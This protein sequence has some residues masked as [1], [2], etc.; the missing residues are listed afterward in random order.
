M[1]GDVHFCC[2]GAEVH[3]LQEIM[4]SRPSLSEED[5]F[6]PVCCDVFNDPVLLACSHSLCRSCLRT[7]WDQR[8]ATECPVCRSLSMNTTPPCNIVLK[9]MCEAILQD[10]RQRAASLSEE[11]G[12]CSAHCQTLTH[13]CERSKKPVCAA[14]RDPTKHSDLSFRTLE[15]AAPD[16]KEELIFKLKPLQ[17]KVKALEGFKRTFCRTTEFIKGQAHQTERLIKEKFEELHQFLREEEGMRLAALK[18]EEEQSCQLMKKKTDDL[19]SEIAFLKDTIRAI[20][21]EIGAESLPFLMNYKSLSERAQ[22]LPHDP[23]RVSGEALIQVAKHLGNLV[24][25]VS[26]RLQSMVQYTPVVLDPN[27][28]NA[29]L[30]LSEDLVSLVS[31]EKQKLLPNNPE[32]FEGFAS[33]L[34]SEGFSSGVHCWDVEVGNSAAWAVG[35]ISESVYRKRQI[36]HKTGLW[37]VGYCGGRYGK[38]SSQENLSALRLDQKVQTLRVQLDWDKGK[39]SFTDVGRNTCLHVVKHRFHETVFPYFYNHCKDHPLKIVPV[40]SSVTVRHIQPV[41]RS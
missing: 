8:G 36:K 16:H 13:F 37:Y 19:N 5:F 20:E 30:S 17:E 6:C 39:V 12:L 9:G 7:F 40:E 33:V 34:G 25:A 38:G 18:E 35:V 41:N 3:H 22:Y 1:P 21:E 14:C 29:N 24:F 28:A 4:A 23:E 27:T 10:R 11:A 32:R 2:R 15:Q 26:S 31:S